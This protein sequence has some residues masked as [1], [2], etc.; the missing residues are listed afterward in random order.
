[1]TRRTRR[2]ILI[3]AVL[4][5]ALITPMILLYAWGYSFDW[6][7][8]NIVLTGGLYLKSIPKK[9]NIYINNQIQ[10][11]ITPTF[12]KRLSP[13]EY[14][15]KV[16]KEGYYSWQ[17]NLKVESKIVT[18]AKNI[19]LIPINPKIEV[20][21]QELPTNFS[22]KDFIQE[23]SNTVNEESVL[24]DKDNQLYLLNSETKEFDLVNQ[25]VQGFQ[26]SSDNQKLL[27]YTP[28][29]I[30]IHHLKESEQISDD[31]EL[32]TRLSQK[33]KQAVW[34]KTN[35]HIIFSTEDNIKILELDNRGDQNIINITESKTQEIAYSIKDDKLYFIQD[36]QL[37]NISLE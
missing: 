13:K 27:Y 2:I 32:I 24:L 23:E 17:K 18:E 3:G 37:I 7:N 31:K 4:F 12:I 30:W 35:E 21:N 15:I 9:A 10:K 29:E 33:I 22:L 14:Q 28:S 16:E 26:F 20:V 1:M 19:L 11:E 8:K 5:F 34:Y 25:N 36:N 6:Q